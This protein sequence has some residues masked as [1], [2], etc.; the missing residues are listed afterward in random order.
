MKNLQLVCAF[1]LLV[2]AGV[3]QD[4]ATA[5]GWVVI[6]INEYGALRG[7]AYPVEPAVEPLPVEATL[8]RVDYDLR[9]DGALVSGRASLTVDVLSDGWVRVPIPPGLLAR[10]ATSGGKLV[11]LVPTPG[12]SGQLSAVLSGKGRALLLLDVIFPVASTGGEERFSLPAGAS[13]VTSASIALAP[14]DV[15]VKVTG[16]FVSEKSATRWR[17]YA[18]GNEPLTFTWRRKIE[19]RRAELPLRMRASLTQLF[20]L[21]EDSTSVSAEAEIDVVQGAARQVRITVPETVTINQVPGATVADWD[22]KDGQLVVNFLDPVER[23]AKFTIAGETRLAREGAMDIPLLRV[24]ETERETGG[25]AVEVLGA[26]EIKETK[27]EGLEAAEAADLGPMVAGRQSP[28]LAAF[29]FRSAAQARSLNVQVA[30]YAQ[31]A[32]LTANIEEARYRVLMSAEGKTLVQARY[33]VRN[34][35]RTFVRIT[36]P[37]GAALWSSSLAGSPVRPGKATDGSLLFPLAKGRVGEEGVL[38]AIE[39][40]YLVRGS[41]WSPKGRATLALP[42]LDL[43][44]SRTGLVLHHPPLFR[45]TPEPGTFRAQSYEPPASPVLNSP[46]GQVHDLP[47]RADRGPA[48]PDSAAQNLVD[49]FRAKSE[50]RKTAAALPIHVS[51]PAVGPSLYL[52]SEL[53]GESKGALVELN[54]QKEKKGGVK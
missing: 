44:V 52:V 6:P 49:R 33:A 15:E 46:V 22:V 40:L 10:E 34:N 11:S 42:A 51:F 13:G 41:A 29:R 2:S 9:L 3:A 53:T 43:P 24:L 25:V 14:Q 7:K 48:P 20:A 23:S 1:F 54:Y 5:P 27:P 19:E 38:F 50:A 8:T 18:R 36:L 16:G 26:G 17:A 47:A 35:Q 37:A 45:V 12:K 31:Q 32:V 21:G 30:R 4:A 28:S 39:I